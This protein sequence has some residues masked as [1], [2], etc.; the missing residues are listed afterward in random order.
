MEIP[1][2]PS[3]K[4]QMIREISNPLYRS[5][6]WIKFLGILL[7]LQGVITAA[8]LFGL[9]IAWLPIWVGLILYRAAKKIEEADAKGEQADLES[10]MKFI[11]QY[12]TIQGIFTLLGIMI[13]I[14]LFI[15]AIMYG[16]WTTLSD[17]M[18]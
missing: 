16:I 2:A 11:S 3:E 6:S 10:A 15:L 12:F 13:S 17:K 1:N 9:I 4:Q 5:K 18:F 14:S 8:T 7:I